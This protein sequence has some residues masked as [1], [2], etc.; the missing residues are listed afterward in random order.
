METIILITL[1]ILK[2]CF[3][4]AK[5]KKGKEKEENPLRIRK[6]LDFLFPDVPE[7]VC[8]SLEGRCCALERGHPFPA[9]PLPSFIS[10]LPRNLKTFFYQDKLI[11]FYL[12]MWPR[13][14]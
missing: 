2:V 13:Q 11:N 1:N 7:A 8:A 3:L 5:E 12:Q 9:L 10:P 14:F 6:R 4:E